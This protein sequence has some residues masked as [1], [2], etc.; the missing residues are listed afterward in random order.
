MIGGN[1]AWGAEVMVCAW[2]RIFVGLSVLLCSSAGVWLMAENNDPSK[3]M[4]IKLGNMIRTSVLTIM[5]PGAL[6]ARDM[7][8]LRTSGFVDEKGNFAYH[9]LNAQNRRAYSEGLRFNRGNFVDKRGKRIVAKKFRQAG[10][11]S[12]GLAAV[13]ETTLWGYLDAT[14]NYAIAPKFQDA[15][16]FREGL[17]PAKCSGLWGYCDET[18]KWMVVPKFE[19][20]LPFSDGLAAVISKG[21]VGYINRRGEMV[22]EPQFD[23]GLSFSDGLAI[24][25]NYDAPLRRTHERCI[26]KTGRIIFD[27]LELRKQLAPN[28]KN[29]W[30][31][32]G[33]GGLD[34]ISAERGVTECSHPKYSIADDQRRYSEG[35]MLFVSDGKFGYLDKNGC[36]AIPIQF[37]SAAP[38]REGLA[39]VSVEPYPV[40]FTRQK[41]KQQQLLG[42]IDHSGKFVIPPIFV[43]AGSFHEGFAYACDK[44]GRSG[45]IDCNGRFV[46]NAAVSIGSNFHDG[47]APV[48][49]FM[50]Y[51]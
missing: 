34:S 27:L 41:Q 20:A 15:T 32:G 48:G 46:I 30:Y 40:N 17:A 29:P 5:L 37:T 36:V 33:G 12:N 45:F 6:I 39:C 38:F 11:F 49:E 18:G 13:C 22:I 28:Q 14:G 42:F 25:T 26:D 43:E 2:Q 23:E 50:S 10:D 31:G 7:V 51:P 47:L 3:P 16:D 24:V 35:L 8:A 19:E 9:E 4:V 1:V 21:K 44:D